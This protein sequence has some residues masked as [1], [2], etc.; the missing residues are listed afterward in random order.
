[1]ETSTLGGEPPC[2]VAFFDRNISETS[3]SFMVKYHVVQT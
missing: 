2:P 3:V 1:M